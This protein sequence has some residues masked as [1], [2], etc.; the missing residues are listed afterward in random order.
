MRNRRFRCTP[1]RRAPRGRRCPG[2]PPARAEE[3]GTLREPV[4]AHLL[5]WVHFEQDARGRDLELRYF[6]DT[7]GREVDFV[8]V[9]GRRPQLLVECKWADAEPDR[10]L[11]DL[12]TRFPA[13]EAWQLSATGRN[14]Y[15]TPE[16]IR[17]APALALLA[18]LI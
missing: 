14:D 7:D 3:G 5:K 2:P 18:R 6:R 4:A 11:R 8:I 16:G 1:P 9:E 15:L 10:S 17:I 13:A 12:K